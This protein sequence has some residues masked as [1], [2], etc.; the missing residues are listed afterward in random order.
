MN[1][2]GLIWQFL[3]I[4]DRLIIGVSHIEEKEMKFEKTA[5]DP[6]SNA[7]CGII[8][9]DHGQI[10]TPIFMPVGTV[11]SVKGIY[12]RDLK[13]D[14]R[15]EIILGN[16]YHLYLR[17]GLDILKAAGGLHKFISWDRPIL[18]DSGGFQVFSLSP[19]R[20]LTPDGCT[21]SSHIDG[22]RH[23]FTPENNVDTQRIIGGDII[24]ALDECTPG[25]ASF[26]YAKKSLKLTQAWLAR[27]I[28]HFDET[29]PL[30]GYSQTFFPIVQGCVYPELR[31]EAAEHAASFDREGYA[32]GGL[33]VGEPTEKMYEMLEVVCPILPDDRPRY[34]MG[35]GTPAN[36]LE[37]IARGVDMFDC[38]MPTRNG[39]NGMLFTWNGIM[40]MK[41]QKWAD[42]FSPIDPEG[43]S[44]VDRTYS[45]AYL[46]HL[47]VSKEIFAGQ[48]ASEH[49]LAFYLDLV[50]EARKHIIAGDFRSWK[51]ATVKR[52]MT[53]L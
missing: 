4:F 13:K 3:L 5:T 39:R 45:K 10:E 7:R 30:Y 20:K 29:E 16:T 37:G 46:R 48:I 15:A 27:C 41:N 49:N 32:I 44:F 43:T 21:F 12:H 23:K 33:S 14:I 8:T 42:D 52:I 47:F 26:D 25:D 18:T 31:R 19:I 35:V 34:L 1:N 2:F 24:M 51:D 50:R 6:G 40:N 17:P 28:R 11:G 53:R 38:V 36:I 22:S 9:T